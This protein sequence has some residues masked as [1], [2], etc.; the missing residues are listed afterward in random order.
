MPSWK[1]IK[2]G[3]GKE[4]E[5]QIKLA[6]GDVHQQH[7]VVEAM[8]NMKETWTKLLDLAEVKDENAP[9]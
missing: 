1:Q 2:E 6:M 4:A 9:L 3:L 7:L 8:A 5:E